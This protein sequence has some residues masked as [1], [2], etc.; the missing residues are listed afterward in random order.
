MQLSQQFEESLTD[1]KINR[2]V[3]YQLIALLDIENDF[4]FTYNEKR[5]LCGLNQR[6]LR[7]E[8]R[9]QRG[10]SILTALVQVRKIDITVGGLAHVCLHVMTVYEFKLYFS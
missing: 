4:F 10:L 6:A 1:E 9:H 3:D 7:E 8:E 5:I 2:R